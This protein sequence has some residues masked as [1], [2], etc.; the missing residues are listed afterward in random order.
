ME[1]STKKNWIPAKPVAFARAVSKPYR[2]WALGAMAAVLVATAASRALTYVLKLLTD[3]AIAFGNGQVVAEAVWRW[4]WVFPAIYLPRWASESLRTRD[5]SPPW[6]YPMLLSY[7][8]IRGVVSLA[9]ALAIPLTTAAGE[10]FPYRDLIL[11]VTFG[12]IIITLVGQGLLLPSFVR[13][14]GLTHLGR[15]EQR[16]EHQIELEARTQ[17]LDAALARLNVLAEERKLPPEVVE[18][19]RARH[20]QLVRQ[21]PKTTP[22]GLDY[23]HQRIDLRVDLIDA[24]RR[25]LYELLRDGKLTDESRRRIERELDLEEEIVAC[26]KEGETPL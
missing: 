6:Q 17:A 23:S 14:L 2:G 24:E 12:V 5:P 1:Q 9:A 16:R 10:P 22:D 7:T 4:V 8:G 15:A 13:W 20:R 19:L 3:D 11:L 25:F 18:S 26:R 21:L